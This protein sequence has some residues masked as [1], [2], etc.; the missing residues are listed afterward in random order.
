MKMDKRDRAQGDSGR[1][2]KQNSK[3]RYPKKRRNK[4]KGKK[5]TLEPVIEQPPVEEL[6]A[7]QETTT[8]ETNQL[9]TKW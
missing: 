1:C 8:P 3:K 5:L 7:V 6:I 9:Q 2:T 4:N